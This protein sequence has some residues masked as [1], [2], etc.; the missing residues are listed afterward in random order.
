MIA[1]PD[2]SYTGSTLCLGRVERYM[3]AKGQIERLGQDLDSTHR[4][5]LSRQLQQ[6]RRRKLAVQPRLC[7]LS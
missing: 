7:T 1:D 2:Y 6:G 3:R 5:Q 4:L